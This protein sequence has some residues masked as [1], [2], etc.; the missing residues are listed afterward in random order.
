[1]L[2]SRCAGIGPFSGTSVAVLLAQLHAHVG[3]QREIERPDLLPEPIHFLRE[4][5]GRHVVL[6]P[7]HRAGIGKSQL[8]GALVR[9]LHEP[10][11]VVAHRRRDGVPALPDFAQPLGVAVF[12]HDLGDLL[13]CPGTR[14][15][16]PSFGDRGHHLPRPY[17]PSMRAAIVVSS[18][19]SFVIARRGHHQRQPQQIQL[20]PLVGWQRELVEPRRLFRELRDGFDVVL[21]GRALS[22]SVSARDEVLLHPAGLADAMPRSSSLASTS[23][24]NAA[25][26]AAVGAAGAAG[27]R[28]ARR[29]HD[30]GNGEG[31]STEHDAIATTSMSRTLSHGRDTSRTEV[32]AQT[33]SSL[34]RKSSCFR[35]SVLQCDAFRF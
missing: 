22:A 4:L 35:G 30:Q 29:R 25:A 9:Q 23:F 19:A 16:G 24:R 13:R 11:I 18:V 1:M 33:A 6:R 5:V 14:L 20:T 27:V 15:F 32:R 12:R 17:A 21:V 26:S 8:L 7:P 3:V 2:P 31:D 10:L 34:Q 28:R